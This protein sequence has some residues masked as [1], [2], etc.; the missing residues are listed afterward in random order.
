MTDHGSWFTSQE[1]KQLTKLNGILHIHAAP[2]HSALNEQSERV[3]KI[4]KEALKNCSN[5]S[6]ET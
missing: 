3:V 1:F 4:V 5:A 2:Y 6:L